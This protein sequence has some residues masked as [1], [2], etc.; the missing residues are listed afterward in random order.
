MN[1]RNPKALVLACAA[2][3]VVL[4][5]ITV[6]AGTVLKAD[7][8]ANLDQLGSW[9][10]GVLPNASDVATWDSTVTSANSVLLGSNLTFGGLKIVNPGGAVTINAGNTLTLGAFGIDMSGATQNLTIGSGL[11]L[12]GATKQTWSVA[13]GRTLTISG[14][15]T[16]SAGATADYNLSAGGT[17]NISSAG[18][19]PAALNYA[20][21]NGGTD[22]AALNASKNIVAAGSA[23]TY[24]ANTASSSANTANLSGTATYLDVTNSNPAVAPSAFRL[25]GNLTTALLRFNQPNA[26]NIDW[27]IDA[28]SRNYTLGAMLVT[29]NVGARDVQM[30]DSSGNVVRMSAGG[31]FILHQYNTAGNVIFNG[32]ITQAAGASAS[33]TLDGLGKTIL[34]NDNNGWGGT[35][36]IN[37]GTLQ[38]GNGGTAGTVGGASIV[39]NGTLAFNQTDSYTLA[40]PIN[41]SGSVQQLGSGT[42]TLSG[43]NTYTGATVLRSGTLSFATGLSNL[44][45]NSELLFNGGALLWP[46]SNTTDI[47]TRT[48]TLQSGGGTVNTNGN[49]VIFA[50]AI[51]NGGSGGLT[52]TGAG[53]L[54]L[55]ASPNYTGLTRVSGGTIVLNSAIGAAGVQ[56]DTAGTL[57]GTATVNGPTSI[58]NGGTIAP[59]LGGIGTFTTNSLTLASGSALNFEF[60]G[61]VNDQIN[62]LSS[63]GLTINGG[64]FNL[65]QPG[66][67]SA[68]TGVGSF[69]LIQYG[70]SIGGSGIGAL[71]ILNPTAGYLYTFGAAGGFVTLNIAQVV[72]ADWSF[73]GSDSWGNAARW[74]GGLVP[75]GLAST[76]NLST[77][78]TAPATITLDAPRTVGLLSMTG[79]AGGS[80]YTLVPGTGGSLTFNNG[81]AATS[82]T[83]NSGVHEISA[84]VTL[85]GATPTFTANVA[86]GASLKMS[87][88]VGG[89]QGL[90][91]SGAGTL[92]LSA[93]N[94]FTGATTV[95]GGTLSIDGNDRLGDETL[96]AAI[97]LNNGSTLATTA[98][99]TLGNGAVHRP[100][101]V[102]SGG[103]IVDT[104][105]GTTLTVPGSFTATSG[106]T[107]NGEGTLLLLAD[108]SATLSAPVTINSGTVSLG[109][110]VAVGQRGIGAGAITLNGGTLALN[111]ADDGNSFLNL[112]NNLIVPATKSAALTMT[113]RGE[114]TGTLTGGGTLNVALTGFRGTWNGNWSAFAGQINFTASG[115]GTKELRLLNGNGFGNARVS[116]GNGVFMSQIFNPPTGSGTQTVQ[117]IGEL[118][119][120]SGAVIGGNPVAGRFVNY[121]VGSLNTSST[122]AGTIQDSAGAARLTKVGTGTLTLSGSNS[123][124]GDLT[125]SAGAVRIG[126]GGTTGTLGSGLVVNNAN[127]IFDRS[128]DYS[129]GNTITGSGSLTQSG[130]GTLFL[131]AANSYSGQTFLNA[132]TLNINGQFALGGAVYAGLTFNGGTLQYASTLSGANGDADITK[133]STGAPKAIAISAGGATIDTNGI[134]ASY[135]NPIGAGGSGSLT[136]KGAG[137]LLLSGGDNNY[138]GM[139][140]VQA[141][142][143][144]VANA[145]S[146]S[147]TSAVTVGSAASLH[148]DGSIISS[149]PIAIAGTLTGG[150][151]LNGNSTISGTLAPGS[152]AG[153]LTFNGSLTLADASTEMEI[154]GNGSVRGAD[155]GGNGYDAVAVTGAGSLVYDGTLEVD[156]VAGIPA[157]DASFDLFDFTS[158]SSSFDDIHIR[159]GGIDLGAVWSVN[160]GT[161]TS[162]L[163]STLFTFSSDSGVLTL[164]AQAVP[165]PLTAAGVLLLCSRVLGRRNRSSL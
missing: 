31:E 55:A 159:S 47:S 88:A 145:A 115:T 49:N 138:T 154:E 58:N 14:T 114:L 84:P 127:L 99:F 142:M 122:F 112:S 126:N 19:V 10:N 165:E 87:G 157:S 41:G 24:T 136:K 43:N 131:T 20:V 68:F 64:G 149:G 11:T 132:G 153:L 33:V 6:H 1:R 111:Q 104:L 12:A 118:S 134:N 69:N 128:D 85:S 17:I 147:S 86:T 89:S 160:A 26:N 107:K 93:S 67:T 77:A 40:T 5:S 101:V 120:T 119:G 91:K 37:Q 143:L 16:R 96:G 71:S 83:M 80:G 25:S 95:N 2:A 46:A 75:D 38:V 117:N 36:Y 152:S 56:A 90:T 59:G 129:V 13:S 53:S 42:V 151:S 162:T 78:L 135:A 156:F 81:T 18:T 98:T 70:G 109:G 66:T 51:G 21:V 72:S 32:K 158:Y 139:T 22:F 61:G 108:N 103:A 62:V 121:T 3:S 9:V 28:N 50:N 7:N 163:G 164:S 63:G 141:G 130:G 54:T 65:F 76:A 123:F 60:G 79:G 137:T 133:T 82:L 74:S 113:P 8:A 52:K 57:T 125:I 35:T 124:S 15:L 100:I 106:L 45:N 148:V 161:W 34:A 92:I 116:L 73:D 146:I 39:N 105:A 27:V 30:N 94:T 150:G 102:G 44:G 23:F 48:V 144:T 110:G 140:F 29:N 4:T 97:A 155:A